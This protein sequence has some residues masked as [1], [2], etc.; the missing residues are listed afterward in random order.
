MKEELAAFNVA[1]PPNNSTRRMARSCQHE[2]PHVAGSCNVVRL[3][4]SDAK[5]K[6]Y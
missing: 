2:P 3:V 6:W 4:E 1:L 5:P